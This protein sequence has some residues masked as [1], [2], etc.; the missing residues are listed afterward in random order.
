M[1][2]STQGGFASSGR[3]WY[4]AGAMSRFGQG[5]AE[6]NGGWILPR[7]AS[8]T[9]VS[10]QLLAESVVLLALGKAGGETTSSA[11]DLAE[12]KISIDDG[13]VEYSYIWTLPSSWSIDTVTREIERR[14]GKATSEGVVREKSTG[15]IGIELPRASS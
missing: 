7:L 11:E 3:A 2:H 15:D 4:S 10:E 6:E 13:Y 9:G 5:V 8:A 14:L 12:F 1:G